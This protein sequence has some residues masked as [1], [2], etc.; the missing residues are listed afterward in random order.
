M[1]WWF[2]LTVRLLVTPYLILMMEM[3]EV[4]FTKQVMAP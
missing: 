3:G 1:E 2:V 4:A